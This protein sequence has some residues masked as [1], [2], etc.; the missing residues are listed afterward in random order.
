MKYSE[1]IMSRTALIAGVSGIV[2]NNLA[3]HLVD[4]GWSVQGLA[5]RPPGDLPGVEPVAT[6]L[7]DPSSLKQALADRRAAKAI[8][9]GRRLGI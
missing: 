3:R 4:T 8:A 6:D 5:R 9:I 2:G 1:T 7:F